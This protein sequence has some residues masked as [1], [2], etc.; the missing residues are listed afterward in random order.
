MKYVVLVAVAA[1]FA[2]SACSREPDLSVSYDPTLAMLETKQRLEQEG[3]TQVKLIEALPSPGAN[4]PLYE[5]VAIAR[6]GKPVNLMVMA[7]GSTVLLPF[8]AR[9]TVPA[10]RQYTCQ[11]NL[12]Q[13][14]FG[15]R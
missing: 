1:S 11:G 10:P 6:G 14:C 2:L 15:A 8:K 5:G 4:P 13:T 12:I 9:Q 3:Y 7:D